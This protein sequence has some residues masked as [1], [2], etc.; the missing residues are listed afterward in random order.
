[1]PSPA[2]PPPAVPDAVSLLQHSA[3]F[4]IGLALIALAGLW[5]AILWAISLP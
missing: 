5:L 4:R 1:M 3:L 2:S